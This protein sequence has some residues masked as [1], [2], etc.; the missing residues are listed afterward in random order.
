MEPILIYTNHTSIKEA[1]QM[2][3]LHFS[4][5]TDFKNALNAIAIEATVDELI[6][7]SQFNSNTTNKVQERRLE[8]FVVNQLLDRAGVPDFNGVP[9]NREKLKNLIDIPSLDHFEELFHRHENYRRQGFGMI[10]ECYVINDGVLALTS[11]ADTVIE[12]IY[13]HYT[14][15]DAGI[16][17]MLKINAICLALDSY[18]EMV[19]IAEYRSG[20]GF[21]QPP[22]IQGISFDFNRGKFVADLKFVRDWEDSHPDYVLESTE[23]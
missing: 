20:K 10:K 16:A 3:D 18:N 15:N 5:L 9:I 8:D 2:K 12:S 21:T 17:L 4:Y 19:K 23:E 7:L 13:T 22:P 6:S 1:K 14:R 11:N